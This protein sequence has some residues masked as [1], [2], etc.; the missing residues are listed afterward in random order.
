MSNA[1]KI[2]EKFT[3]SEIL[4]ADSLRQL[5]DATKGSAI[6]ANPSV[7]E[8]GFDYVMVDKESGEAL[9][10]VHCVLGAEKIDTVELRGM[11]G[12][13]IGSRHGS[14]QA[15]D[16]KKL[17]GIIIGARELSKN[18]RDLLRNAEEFLEYRTPRSVG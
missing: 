17:K 11:I 16:G 15:S 18:A 7:A 10:L 3:S 5:L 9:A 12:G 1:L 6:K 2:L 8:D 14:R 13:V 4:E